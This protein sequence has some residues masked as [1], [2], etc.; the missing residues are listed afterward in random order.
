VRLG[1]ARGIAPAAAV[2]APDHPGLAVPVVGVPLAGAVVGLDG[3][4][5]AIDVGV[6]PDQVFAV[7]A[8]ETLRVEVGGCSGEARDALRREGDPNHIDL[9]VDVG[10]V[11]G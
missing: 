8:I 2:D 7:A 9:A 4:D 6:H 1:R 11:G 10:A 3:C 5:P